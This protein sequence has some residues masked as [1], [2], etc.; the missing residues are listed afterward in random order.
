MG[1]L[2]RVLSIILCLLMITPA[3]SATVL[4]EEKTYKLGDTVTYN[5]NEATLPTLTEDLEWSNPQVSKST[6]P[7]CGK[8]EGH[9]HSKESCGSTHVTDY[10]EIVRREYNYEEDIYYRCTKGGTTPN[11]PA[12]HPRHNDGCLVLTTESEWYGLDE[13]ARYIK[14]NYYRYN[15]GQ[16]EGHT[17]SNECYE[18]LYTWT[19][20]ASK[21]RAALHVNL[22]FN[23]M[24]SGKSVSNVSVSVGYA[25]GSTKKLTKEGASLQY[26]G[27]RE[28]AYISNTNDSDTGRISKI[29]VNYTYDG[30]NRNYT[31][32]S[33]E[34]LFAAHNLCQEKEGLDFEITIPAPQYYYQIIKELYSGN[35]TI[36]DTTFDGEITST[37][38]TFVKPNEDASIT[39]KNS[40]YTLETTSSDVD[41]SSSKDDEN[42]AVVIKLVYRR[43]PSSVNYSWKKGSE[44]PEGAELPQEV[45]YYEGDLVKVAS[46]PKSIE[47]TNTDGKKGTWTFLGWDKNDF[48]MGKESITITGEWKF[49][50]K[51]YT[52]TYTDGVAAE[53][54]FE[55]K[56]YEGLT[57]GENTPIFEGI[58]T[59]NGYKFNGW[60]PEISET[61]IDDITYS[62]T[63]VE[64]SE[65]DN[66]SNSPKTGDSFPFAMTILMFS[67]IAIAVVVSKIKKYI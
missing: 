67:S 30:V 39:Y 23:G 57:F 27:I 46:A 48:T 34:G 51:T 61:I 41:I 28:S 42:K 53:I 13:R 19:A 16:V 1:K 62:A 29:I 64:V 25:D 44:V 22:T 24:E 40:T 55:D 60:S 2:N 36:A 18:N 54:V 45:S 32:D 50:E 38:S 47:G 3:F 7:S 6:Q 63:W 12:D 5:N 59:R 52:I 11:N 15:C 26:T 9:I 14:R 49:E 43:Q 17:H 37:E 31:V 35:S 4:A 65:Q 21:I 10:G 66:G 20:V 8:E 33:F 56:V 58:P